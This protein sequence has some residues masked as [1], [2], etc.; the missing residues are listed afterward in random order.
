MRDNPDVT[1]YRM[2]LAVTYINLGELYF[3]TDKSAEALDIYNE[4]MR[5]Q[6]P[7]VRDNP[8]VTKYKR[9][10]AGIHLNMG[11]VYFERGLGQLQEALEC[12]ERALELKP[13]DRDQTS[14]YLR[15]RGVRYRAVSDDIDIWCAAKG[16]IIH[17]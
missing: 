17:C 15:N 13:D 7:L 6:E 14:P 16:P 3:N 5:I 9:D 11:V 2:E 8:D 1:E 4:A 10:L 12:Y